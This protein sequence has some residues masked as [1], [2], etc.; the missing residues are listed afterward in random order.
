MRPVPDPTVSDLIAEGEGT[1][2]II[3]QPR[4]RTGYG[5]QAVI[6]LATLPPFMTRSYLAQLVVCSACGG[7][8][9]QPMRNITAHYVCLREFRCESV[10]HRNVTA[11][12][13]G[14]IFA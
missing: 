11:N 6:S 2:I 4:E 3:C 14:F 13:L 12:R 10:G 9:G 5:Q 8:G 7:R 1:V